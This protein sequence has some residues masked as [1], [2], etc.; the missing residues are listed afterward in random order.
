MDYLFLNNRL[1]TRHVKEDA[2][3][4]SQSLYLYEISFILNQNK[5]LLLVSFSNCL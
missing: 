1:C 2:R 3:E 5:H 4:N